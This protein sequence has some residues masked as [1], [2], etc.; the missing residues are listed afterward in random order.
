MLKKDANRKDT[1]KMRKVI[2]T[3][4]GFVLCMMILV[5]CGQKHHLKIS[6]CK[7]DTLFIAKNGQLELV[8]VEK[9]DKSY[10]DQK[11]LK[12]Y[13]QDSIKDFMETNTAAKVKMEQFSVQKKEAKVLLT[14]D[15]ADTYQLFQ[16]EKF[17]L[18]SSQEV[19]S[20]LVL[21]ENFISAKDGKT[22]SKATVLNEKDLYFLIT[23]GALDIQLDG[24]IVYYSDASLTGDNL[25][26][27]TGDK[28]AVVIYKK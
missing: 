26:Q 23:K 16:Q 18:L 17:Q 4:A 15:S 22:V 24:K 13:I 19:E 3:S 8:D 6:D 14:F 12:N 7:N 10:Y 25:I 11:E 1:R 28:T 20:N 2:R 9:F 21:P 27:T 5:G